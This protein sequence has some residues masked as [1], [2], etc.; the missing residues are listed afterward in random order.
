MP[1]RSWAEHA[2]FILNLGRASLSGFWTIEARLKGASVGRGVTFIGRPLISV[3]KGSRFQL[4]D[5]VNIN[6]SL[7]ANPLGCFQPCVLRTLCP[8]AE[9][10]LE[11]QV[12]IS[13]CV[14]CAAQS[15]SIGQGTFIGSGAMVL[16]NDFHVPAGDFDWADGREQTARRIRIGRGVFIG[17]RAIVLKGVTIGDR[18]VIGAGAVVTKS[19]PPRHFAV[20]NP[21]RIFPI[22]DENPGTQPGS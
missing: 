12:G 11:M 22:R 15:V 21:V 10:V 20:G 4:G 13:G 16:D 9:L 17:A 8:G 6:S 2:G 18:A 7:R 3:A 19:V 1:K 5:H 14:L